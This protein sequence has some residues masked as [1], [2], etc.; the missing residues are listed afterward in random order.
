M[1]GQAGQPDLLSFCIAVL[2]NVRLGALEYDATL[3]LVR[4]ELPV[5]RL[6]SRRDGESERANGR[7][8]PERWLTVATASIR[9]S[10]RTMGL[11]HH[12]R[13]LPSFQY[14]EIRQYGPFCAVEFPKI[15][16]P[17]PFLGSCASSIVSRERGCRLAWA[18][19]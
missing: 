8:S 4:L 13:H 7:F 15:W 11:Y 3:L 18:R 9:R 1:L 2:F 6:I 10:S 5:S 19:S 16:P 17:V 12:L 14:Y